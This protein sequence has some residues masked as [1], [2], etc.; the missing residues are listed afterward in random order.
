[1]FTDRV[2]MKMDEVEESTIFELTP[3]FGARYPWKGRSF[4]VNEY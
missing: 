2:R 3:I 1:M 4:D